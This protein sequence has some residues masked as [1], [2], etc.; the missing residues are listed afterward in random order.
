MLTRIFETSKPLNFLW[1]SLFLLLSFSVD[2]FYT[3]GR[4]I[5]LPEL[6]EYVI[7]LGL[8]IFSVLL[9]DFI[10]RK[11][12]LSQKNSF[13]VLLYGCFMALLPLSEI[14]LKGIA[15]QVLVL[16]AIRRIIS[17][18]SLKS[19]KKKLFDAA[20]WI[21]IGALLWF[22]AGGMIA[23]VFLGVLLFDRLDYRNWIIPLFGVATVLVLFLTAHWMITDQLPEMKFLS[24]WK[25]DFS[26][27]TVISTAWIALY[28]FILSA[29]LLPAYWFSFRKLMLARKRQPLLIV[30]AVLVSWLIAF[31]VQPVAT[32]SLVFLMFPLGVMAAKLSE[33]NSKRPITELVLWLFLL[34]PFAARTVI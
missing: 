7:I 5:S 29:T 10:V 16:L 24:Q 9:V 23:L 31:F 21:T 14:G 13:V 6:V 28:F 17:L 30:L 4:G 20:F 22:A 18:R 27:W 25:I 32:A 8:L 11:N 12:N 34:L 33:N 2:W 19:V 26:E 15:A 3:A 1:V